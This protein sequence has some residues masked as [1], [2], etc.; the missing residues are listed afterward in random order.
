MNFDQLSETDHELKGLLKDQISMI[1]FFVVDSWPWAIKIK[2]AYIGFC[3]Q[4]NE[5]KEIVPIKKA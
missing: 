3:G 2:V 1:F 4:C 5:K